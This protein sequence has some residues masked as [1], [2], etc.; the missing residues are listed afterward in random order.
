MLDQIFLPLFSSWPLTQSLDT[1]VDSETHSVG[2]RLRVLPQK[3]S[4][5]TSPQKRC[6][7]SLGLS[8][9][10]RH[11]VAE[12]FHSWKS[13]HA[14]IG[15]PKK[16]SKTAGLK[17]DEKTIG[18][19]DENMLGKFYNFQVFALVCGPLILRWG[20]FFPCIVQS[21]LLRCCSH[22][23]KLEIKVWWKYGGAWICHQLAEYSLWSPELQSLISGN[24]KLNLFYVRETIRLIRFW[25]IPT[26]SSETFDCNTIHSNMP[27]TS[28]PTNQPLLYAVGLNLSAESFQSSS[29]WLV[30]RSAVHFGSIP[31]ITVT[32]DSWDGNTACWMQDIF[33]RS[34]SATDWL[35]DLATDIKLSPALWLWFCV[36]LCVCICI[37]EFV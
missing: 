11:Q 5:A 29:L 6:C 37:C 19:V 36:F 18:D 16:G 20:A 21:N 25:I 22:A 23:G 7:Y 10:T 12:Y 9:L 31:P 4:A 34:Q 14:T 24:L 17:K 15:W 26:D 8:P 33:K 32:G 1:E 27:K 2:R 13:H 35:R 28:N 3:R 30:A